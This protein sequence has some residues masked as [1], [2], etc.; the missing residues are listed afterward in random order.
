[1]CMLRGHACDECRDTV[2]VVDYIDVA[3]GKQLPAAALGLDRVTCD[4]REFGRATS[5]GE[6]GAHGHREDTTLEDVALL[7]KGLAGGVVD[8]PNP[9]K[10]GSSRDNDGDMARRDRACRLR[11]MSVGQGPAKQASAV[12]PGLRGRR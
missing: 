7:G 6:R 4:N 8:I 10:P 3:A 5:S 12:D 1:M 11:C 9:A 2:E